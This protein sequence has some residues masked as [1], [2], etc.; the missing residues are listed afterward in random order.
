MA[1]AWSMGSN[2]VGVCVCACAIV[3]AMCMWAI[4][5][6]CVPSNDCI[7]SS[8]AGMHVCVRAVVYAIL[9]SVGAYLLTMLRLA[10]GLVLESCNAS[11]CVYLRVHV[12]VI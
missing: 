12:F 7:G 6:S 5:W 1:C 8:T 11:V 3:R 9:L 10:V 4:F 2:T